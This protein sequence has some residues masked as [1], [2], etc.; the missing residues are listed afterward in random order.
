V[1]STIKRLRKNENFQT[2]FVIVLIAVVI[3]SLWFGAQ[4]ILNTRI[5]PILAVTSG[6]MCI[7]YG[8]ALCKDWFSINH[9]FERTLHTGDLIIIQGVDPDKLNTDYPNSD[10]I[11][12]QHPWYPTD[13]NEKI[14][15]RIV[16]TTEINGT[17]HFYTKGDGN[18]ITKWPNT[19]ST[20]EHDPWSPVP[21]DLV[22]GKVIMRIPWIGH[23]PIFIQNLSKEMGFNASYI[24]TNSNCYCHCAACG[25]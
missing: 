11:V 16:G 6:S 13:P 12:Y 23:L 10:I 9:P 4:A 2:L 25:N 1:T 19:L 7:P 21:A 15:H 22:Y 14:V 18:P 3:F 24:I 20:D 5:T 8:G 17:L